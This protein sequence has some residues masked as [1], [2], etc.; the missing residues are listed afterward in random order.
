MNSVHARNLDL[1]PRVQPDPVSHRERGALHAAHRSRVTVADEL[2]AS[3]A[4]RT[5]V[6]SHFVCVFDP[7][8]VR[9]GSSPTERAHLAQDHVIV[10][11]NADLRGVV[12]DSYGRERRVRCSVAS[13]G[14]VG[15]IVD[16]GRLVATVPS[17]VAAQILR[18][19]PHLR[20]STIPFSHE[21]GS[22]D[23]LWPTALDVD[24]GCR[25]VRDAI[26]RIALSGTGSPCTGPIST[27]S[28]TLWKI[29]R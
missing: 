1:E 18:N 9:L 16:G 20:T 23:L 27:T 19:R 8:F 7:R 29:T 11:Y 28:V 6:L 17:I 24:P 25:F 15:A 10:S 2:P 3:V 26:V 21:P 12:E 22:V 14:S 13:F 4:R 5:L